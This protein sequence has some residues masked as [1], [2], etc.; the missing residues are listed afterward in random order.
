MKS[1]SSELMHTNAMRERA[2]AHSPARSS[3]GPFPLR[4][5]TEVKKKSAA[6]R[7][8]SGHSGIRR[9]SHGRYA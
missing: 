6:M 1:G 7:S 4:H 8:G 3:G 9:D 2:V 5:A